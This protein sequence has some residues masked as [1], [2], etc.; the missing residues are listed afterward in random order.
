MDEERRGRDADTPTEIPGPGWRDVLARTK[1][2][3]K[4]DNVALLAAGVAFFALLAVVPALVAFVSLYGLAADPEDIARHVGDVLGAAPS[5]VRE[6]IEAQ[7]E[8]I[9]T[10]DT[11]GAGV[12]AILGVVVALWSASS[13]MKHAIT[14]VNIAYDEP[15]TRGFLKLRVLSLL[16]TMGALIFGLVAFALIAVL[17]A[18]LA[19][20]ALGTPGRIAL[21]ILRWPLLAG[22]LLLALAVFYRYAPNRDDPRWRWV[23]P[24]AIAATVLWLVGSAAFSI[25]AANFG[26]YNETYGSLGGI[27]VVMLWLFLTAFLVIAGAEL[28]AELERQTRK[29]TTEGRPRPM[30]VRQAYAADT[31]GETAEEVRS[32]RPLR[33]RTP[34]RGAP[35]HR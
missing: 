25:Y 5:E 16:L 23:S 26:N 34:A 18:A 19:N 11:T 31:L 21:G 12:G 32:R 10:G 3:S 14:G 27:V 24:G 2:D 17:P 1:A 22:V 30:G 35:A 29:D 6:L 13:G 7:L 15:E 9:T 33:G 28:N 4:A 8:D 20:S